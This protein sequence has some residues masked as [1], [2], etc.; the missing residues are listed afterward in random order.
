MCDR[1]DGGRGRGGVRRRGAA[2]AAARV[3]AAT[4]SAAAW[5]AMRCLAY[6]CRLTKILMSPGSCFVSRMAWPVVFAQAGK[7][8]REPGSVVCTSIT[9][10]TATDAD[11]PG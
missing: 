4:A 9:S 6:F 7:S 2:A 10:P 11:L 8:D 5:A 1:L 3:A